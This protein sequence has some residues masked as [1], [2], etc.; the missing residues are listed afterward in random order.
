MSHKLLYITLKLSGMCLISLR[1]KTQRFLHLYDKT[2]N[3]SRS[4]ANQIL[5]YVR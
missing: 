2:D 5:S 1:L 3:A 4:Y